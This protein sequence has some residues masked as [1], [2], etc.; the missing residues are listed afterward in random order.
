[1]IVLADCDCFEKH[2][3][4][5]TVPVNHYKEV[6]CPDCGEEVLLKGKVLEGYTNTENGSGNENV[7]YGIVYSI[8]G[9]I[10]ETLLVTK[11]KDDEDAELYYIPEDNHER[12]DS[13]GLSG[14]VNDL[15]RSCHDNDY[16]KT[17][18]IHTFL[19]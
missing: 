11:S 3:K 15:H 10:G 18:T 7:K 6:E 2:S 17:M 4:D 13:L 14:V 9:E 8:I 12:L 16:Y 19:K 1:M 5:F